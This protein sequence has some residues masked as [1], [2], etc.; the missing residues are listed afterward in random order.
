MAKA[1]VWYLDVVMATFIFAAG[2]VA[3]HFYS[4]NIDRDDRE[5]LEE[6]SFQADALSSELLK[7]GYPK[8][9]TSVDVVKI[10]LTN[11]DQHL[12]EAQWVEFSL[13]DYNTSK[14][15]LG[16]TY[17]FLVFFENAQGNVTPFGGVCGVGLQ[18]INFTFSNETCTR[19]VLPPVKNL[20]TRERYLFGKNN[21]VK[22]KVYVFS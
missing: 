10:G 19:P 15:L 4:L 9:W 14:Q 22:M 20:L 21:I 12:D 6:M 11:N 7:E 16:M 5:R 18:E 8:E 2:L 13:V 3:F 1:Q 17:D